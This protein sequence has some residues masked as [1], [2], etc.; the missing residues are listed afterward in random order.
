MFKDTRVSMNATDK[1]SKRRELEGQAHGSSLM[2]QDE[3]MKVQGR[4]TEESDEGH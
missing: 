3:G 4:M 1:C 2:S